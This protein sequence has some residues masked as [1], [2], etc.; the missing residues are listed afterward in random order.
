M[1]VSLIVE[2]LVNGMKLDDINEPYTRILRPDALSQV[3]QV[4]LELSESFIVAA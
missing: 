4:A 2:C 3:V 1:S